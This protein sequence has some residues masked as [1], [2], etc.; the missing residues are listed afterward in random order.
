[1]TA[2]HREHT[3][4]TLTGTIATPRYRAWRLLRVQRWL[5]RSSKGLCG[6]SKS[7]TPSDIRIYCEKGKRAGFANLNYCKSSLCVV[8]NRQ[9]AIQ[10]KETID[11]TLKKAYDLNLQPWFLTF[12]CENHNDPEEQLN[13]INTGYKRLM[14]NLRVWMKRN[15]GKEVAKDIYAFRSVDMTIKKTLNLYHLHL[16]TIICLPKFVNLR[17]IALKVKSSFISGVESKG[18]KAS[19]GGQD[20]Q[21]VK[22]EHLNSYLTSF[23]SLG[24]ELSLRDTKK[25]KSSESLSLPELMEL[26]LKEGKGSK[27]FKCYKKL[28]YSLSG[29]R[30]F[31]RTRNIKQIITDEE[32]EEEMVSQ[33]ESDKPKEEV[34]ITIDRHVYKVIDRLGMQALCLKAISSYWEEDKRPYFLLYNFLNVRYDLKDFENFKI[35]DDSL[36]L[37]QALKNLFDKIE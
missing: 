4:L 37:I 15:Y 22:T 17:D 27:A 29:K 12:T 20:I 2:L 28:I 14:D 7:N 16:H 13:A 1:M 21:K 35:Y 18:L 31:D 32:I 23:L 24:S 5:G 33:N 6:T 19:M 36:I 30:L 26:S 25:A 10:R 8:C 9:K 11:I 34:T 3:G